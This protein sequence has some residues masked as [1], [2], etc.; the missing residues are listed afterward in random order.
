[1]VDDTA[2]SCRFSRQ[3][4]PAVDAASAG[5]VVLVKPGVYNPFI[6]DGKSLCV[7]G[8]TP[9][10]LRP[11]ASFE[12]R[13]LRSDQ[14]VIVRGFTCTQP[15]FTNNFG[16]V[17]VEDCIWQSSSFMTSSHSTVGF[18]RSQLLDAYRQQGASGFF[19]DSSI[20]FAY[21]STFHGMSGREAY[22]DE[23]SCYRGYG[24][25][26]SEGEPGGTA[27]EIH[28]G[29][30]YLFGCDVTGG[31]GGAGY[32]P[33]C[34][35]LFGPEYLL[36]GCG[37]SGLILSTSMDSVL[38]ETRA[39]AGAQFGDRDDCQAV[40]VGTFGG[41][42]TRLRGRTGEFSVHSPARAGLAIRY[43]FKGPPGWK[44][45][46]TY[47]LEYEPTYDPALHGMSV[48]PLDSRTVFLGTLPAS[49]ELE[50]RKSYGN[51]LE[52][53]S[54]ARVIYVQAKFHDPSTCY[55]VLGTP[56]VL[57]VVQDCP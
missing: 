36:E 11:Q 49:G 10:I 47:A 55:S 14:S 16:P 44:V 28:G 33:S 43:H 19:A 7:I 56:S 13:N 17:W 5:D 6:V 2:S 20:I 52:P 8:E 42:L 25:H 32:T 39:S 30:A 50:V 23:E 38:L 41:T 22:F 31:A 15:K 34:T 12:V 57:V 48:V 37:G 24:C 1:V 27:F 53:G 46:V 54:E 51:V 40:D 21:H 29:S 18:F 3:I 45:F 35:C 4:Q 26:G 9:R